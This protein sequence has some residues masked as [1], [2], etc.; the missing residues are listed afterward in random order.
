MYV[1]LQIAYECGPM[2]AVPTV[3]TYQYIIYIYGCYK[4]VR[5]YD[6]V[7][8]GL[9]NYRGIGSQGQRGRM[10]PQPFSSSKTKQPIALLYPLLQISSIRLSPPFRASYTILPG[11]VQALPIK[12]DKLYIK[13]H[14]RDCLV[15]TKIKA[16]KWWESLLRTCIIK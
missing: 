6:T 12:P 13:I 15:I 10:S 11:L 14:D 3:N 7:N 8:L 16:K 4:L 2:Y 1:S 9:I 5:F